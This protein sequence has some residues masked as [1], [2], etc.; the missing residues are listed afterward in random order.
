MSVEKEVN[1]DKI[2]LTK[3]IFIY[4][5]ITSILPLKNGNFAYSVNDTI[6]LVKPENV[7]SPY[8]EIKNDEECRSLLELED[9]VICAG[10]KKIKI[11]N[12]SKER[13]EVKGTIKLESENDEIN[14][15]L[16]LPG[17]RLAAHTNNGITIYKSTA[18]YSDTPVHVVTKE[19][20]I[21]SAI[22][23]KGRDELV[24]GG[25]DKKAIYCWNMTNY[26]C[27]RTVQLEVPPVYVSIV[28]DNSVVFTSSETVFIL[29]LNQGKVE[30]LGTVQNL[31]YTHYGKGVMLRDGHSMLFT[32]G[33]LTIYDFKTKTLKQKKFDN[34]V[35]LQRL[36]VV[37][38]NTLFSS[39]YGRVHWW[40][41]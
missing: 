6:F 33:H 22:Y 11:W 14:Q 8:L 40:K 28:D 17:E 15:L 21:S 26:Q 30:Q 41:Y 1:I 9:G 7:L 18:P 37:N 3:Q 10:C 34:E 5:D 39:A 23:V 4:G 2:R 32:A 38:D 19:K 16:L 25:Y 24:A 12:I 36:Y 27:T 20:K 29:Y 35:G 31:Y 13:A